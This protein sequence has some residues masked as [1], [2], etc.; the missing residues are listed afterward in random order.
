MLTMKSS[1][2]VSRISGVLKAYRSP[3]RTSCSTPSPE[4]ADEPGAERQHG[5]VPVLD[6]TRGDQGRQPQGLAAQRRLC[7]DEQAA[8][9]YA[10][11]ERARGD[12]EQQDGRELERADQPELERRRC[13]LE[14]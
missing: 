13:E 7:A 8:F 12:G 11:R 10:V 9:A 4:R 1:P 6:V 5:D 2:R 3:V 14:H